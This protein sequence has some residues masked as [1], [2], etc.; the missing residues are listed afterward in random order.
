MAFF[1]GEMLLAQRLN[2]LQ[3]IDYE[4]PATS[5]LAVAT[6]TYADIPGASLTITTETTGAT[7]KAIGIFDCNV[8]TTSPTIL[9]V[10]RLLVDGVG[11]EGI[12]IYAMDTADRATIAMT[13]R[14]SLGAAGSHTLKL[15]GALNGALASGGSFLQS[16]TKLSVTVLEVV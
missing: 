8:A 6:A 16:D 14:G 9:M 15:Q 2:R 10:G 1:A 3:P 5:P 7:Y 4:A 13:W 12:A 11:A